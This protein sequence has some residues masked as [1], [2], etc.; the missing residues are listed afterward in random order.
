[1]KKSIVTE[2]ICMIP[3]WEF[4]GGLFGLWFFSKYDFYITFW[5]WL[6]LTGLISCGITAYVVLKFSD[7]FNNAD[8]NLTSIISI[9]TTQFIAIFLYFQCPYSGI[10]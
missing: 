9:F 7:F 5:I 4:W 8:G 6:L 10:L 1:M 2:I 3:I